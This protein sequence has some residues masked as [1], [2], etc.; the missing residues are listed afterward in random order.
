MEKGLRKFIIVV[1]AI[2][3]IVVMY[4]GSDRGPATL[5]TASLAVVSA[6]A[7]F[8]GA[9]VAVHNQW[10]SGKNGGGMNA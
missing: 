9:N 1:I 8:F 6:A 4:F 7:L 3:A 5:Q 10:F 2:I